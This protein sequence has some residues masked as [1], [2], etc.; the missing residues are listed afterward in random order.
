MRSTLGWLT[1]AA[2]VLLGGTAW[3]GGGGAPPGGGAGGGGPEPEVYALMLFS[4]LPG[5]FFARRALAAR[6]ETSEEA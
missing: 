5:A 4:L 6:R 2:V 1:V 3:A